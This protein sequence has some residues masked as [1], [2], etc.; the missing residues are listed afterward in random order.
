MAVGL[1]A[2]FDEVAESWSPARSV[3][4]AGTPD[5]DRWKQAVERARGWD[6]NLSSL[7]F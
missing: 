5:R 7:D 4:P 3:E 6:P 1:W 2:D